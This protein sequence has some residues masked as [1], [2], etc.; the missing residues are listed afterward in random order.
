VDPFGIRVE[1]EAGEVLVYKEELSDGDLAGEETVNARERVLKAVRAFEDEAGTKS[2]IVEATGL[3]EGTVKK[4]LAALKREEPPRVWDTGRVEG[5]QAIITTRDP[6]G[7]GSKIYRGTG[8]G[9][10]GKAGTNE[11]TSETSSLWE[12][13]L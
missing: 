4:E 5:R 11:A 13:G 6:S 12:G 10:D 1:F 7:S 9:T 3:A 8:T 2:D